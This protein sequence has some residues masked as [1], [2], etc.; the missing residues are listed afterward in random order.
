MLKLQGYIT[1]E[2]DDLPGTKALL[3]QCPP[4]DSDVLI[5]QACIL[6]KEKKYEEARQKFAEAMNTLGYK[7]SIAYNIAVCFY[8]MKQ[9]AQSRKYIIE[10]IEKGIKEHPGN[11]PKSTKSYNYRTRNRKQR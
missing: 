6:F 3:E 7:P 11:D 8:Y 9:H 1:Y 5:T 2:Q 10:I 4:D